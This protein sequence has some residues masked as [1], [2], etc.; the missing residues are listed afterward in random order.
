MVLASIERTRQRASRALAVCIVLIAAGHGIA[1]GAEH[2]PRPA[3]AAATAVPGLK[4]AR[5]LFQ[6]GKPREAEAAARRLLTLAR[7]HH[8]DRSLEAA[9]VMDLLAGVLRQT[10]PATDPEAPHLASLALAIKETALGSMARGTAA[11]AYVLAHVVRDPGDPRCARDLYRRVVDIRRATPFTDPADLAEALNNLGDMLHETAD[12]VGAVGAYDEAIGIYEAIRNDGGIALASNGMGIAFFALGDTERSLRWSQRSLALWEK[13]LPSGDPTI[14][15]VVNN[16]AIGYAVMGDLRTAR[17]CFEEVLAIYERR[18]ESSSRMAAVVHGNLGMLLSSLGDVH[19]AR[20]HYEK[21]VEGLEAVL[22]PW[23][24]SVAQALTRLALVLEGLGDLESAR[25]ALE[26]VLAIH[27]KALGPDHPAVGQALSNLG[28]LAMRQGYDARARDL[29]ERS[30]VIR[31]GAL[32]PVHSEVA[33]TLNNLAV[34]LARV[35]EPDAAR[36]AFERALSIREEAF[37]LH[38]GSVAST[39]GNLAELAATRGDFEAARSLAERALA[40]V[41]EIAGDTS[42]G[43]VMHRARL[44]HIRFQQGQRARALDAALEA[45]RGRRVAVQILLSGLPEREAL[46]DRPD[47]EGALDVAVA[48]ATGTRNAD[49]TRRTWDAVLRAR[50]LVLDEM[51]RRHRSLLTSP[52]PALRRLATEMASQKERLAALVV[53]GSEGAERREEIEHARVAAEAA[54]RRLAEQ[55]PDRDAALADVGWDDVVT[56]LPPR[57]ALVA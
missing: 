14:A 53:G 17:P 48:V 46:L 37:G 35:G 21:S 19:A 13:L 43:A 29:L 45:E 41:E 42:L 11:S 36:K 57:S 44:A 6:A 52:T 39:L 51:A 28:I 18:D 33:E 27:E 24:P 20:R 25:P 55:L 47:M 16:I 54:E 49:T 34:L 40:I 38:H 50:A 56:A 7:E 9:D 32:G 23:H 12:N 4:D 8:G 5:S 22:G 15:M 3:A 30:L 10:R 31:E 26:R 2:G 1:R